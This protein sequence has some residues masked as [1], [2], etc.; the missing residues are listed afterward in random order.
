MADGVITMDPSSSKVI[1]VDFA[2]Y[3]PTTDS[4]LNN[5][6]SGSTIDAYEVGTGTDVGATVLSSKT[7]TN[8]TLTVL[9]GA[10]TV[11]KEYRLRFIGQ[12][13]TSSQKFTRWFLVLARTDGETEI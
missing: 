1:T 12:G 11:G 7:R 13:A 9:V 5:I 2:P 8:K 3:L 10:L 6:A 4:A